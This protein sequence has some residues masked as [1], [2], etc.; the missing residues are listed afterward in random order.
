MQNNAHDPFDLLKI[1]PRIIVSPTYRLNLFG[2]L[3]GSAL[4]TESPDQ[5]IGNYG[6]WDQRMALEWTAKNIGLFGGNADNISVGGLS[7][8]AYSTIFQLHYDMRRPKSKDRHI[9][10]I[11]LYS[12]TVGI[13]PNAVDSADAEEQFEELAGNLNVT[14]DKAN[15][16]KALEELRAIP[17]S[18]LAAV[19][20]QLKHH[21]FRAATDN[22]FISSS[23]LSSIHD[24][25]FAQT[26]R[27]RNISILLGEVANEETMYRLVNPAKSYS[28]LL[29]QL[30]NYYP[31]SVTQALLPHYPLPPQSS[32]DAAA[33]KHVGARMIADCQIHATIRGWTNCLKGVNVY[34]YRIS[35]RAKSLDDWLDPDVGL[36]HASDT[37]I[38]WCSGFRAGY[39]EEDIDCVKRFIKP[40]EDFL[41]GRRVEW[42]GDG[43]RKNAP[44]RPVTAYFDYF[45]SVRDQIIDEMGPGVEKKDVA[46]EAVRRW[47]VMNAAEK[48]RWEDA[49]IEKMN[50]YEDQWRD[51]RINSSSAVRQAD[52]LLLREFGPDGVIR[53][54]ED[55]F[56]DRG[57]EIW[58]AMRA[59]QLD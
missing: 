36:C 44:K 23:F 35:W 42:V 47:T 48:A 41:W 18:Q 45:H 43:T 57:M 34:R 19:I 40:F 22:D 49:Y 9:K 13:Q 16:S 46:A 1:S 2:F 56:W 27:E 51:W 37:P 38:W 21:T 8:G 6:F 4:S 58:E 31:N 14:I 53:I 25:S 26:L 12:N 10:R 54:V 29:I 33:W 3:A 15:P 11:F 50:S 7:A 30:N 32:R 17:D 28:D 59:A 39:S 55:D 24:G 20:P 5:A 52:K